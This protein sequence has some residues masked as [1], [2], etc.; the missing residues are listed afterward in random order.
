MVAILTYG[1]VLDVFVARVGLR[2]TWW[3]AALVVITV[4]GASALLVLVPRLLAGLQEG[5]AS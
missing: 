1:V 5:G 4:N 3:R 2:L